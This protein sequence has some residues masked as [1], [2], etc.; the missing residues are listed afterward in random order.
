MYIIISCTIYIQCLFSWLSKMV[1]KSVFFFSDRS[2]QINYS[3]LIRGCHSSALPTY[4]LIPAAFVSANVF[5]L[6]TLAGQTVGWTSALFQNSQP[7]CSQIQ[8]LHLS[9][10]F[11]VCLFCI[12]SISTN[13][14][15]FILR[16]ILV[17]VF[18]WTITH[19]TS[20][21]I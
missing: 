9:F 4:M 19:K 10:F 15:I 5:I 13:K 1:L 20:V 17:K 2:Q 12:F 21:V 16:K 6:C 14:Y 11:F 3:G 7:L 8:S 18:L